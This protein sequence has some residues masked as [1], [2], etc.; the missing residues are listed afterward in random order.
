MR[1][2]RCWLLRGLDAE[3]GAR[4][5]GLSSSSRA[6]GGAAGGD[7]AS[8]A[9]AFEE[10]AAASDDE[11]ALEPLEEDLEDGLATAEGPEVAAAD[12]D[13]FP[14]LPLAPLPDPPS[15]PPP[16]AAA[17]A[18]ADC[19]RSAWSSFADALACRSLASSLRQSPCSAARRGATIPG[20]C[21]LR[22]FSW[23]SFRLA[24]TTCA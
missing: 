23:A 11:D 16:L 5:G 4:W 8:A 24:M 3:K 12:E 20:S 13:D 19:F 15:P 2:R 10:A 7:F 1:C 22:R 21:S 14:L 17:A 6:A 18:A 9:A